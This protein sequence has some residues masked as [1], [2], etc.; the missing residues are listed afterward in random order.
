MEHVFNVIEIKFND[1]F[2]NNSY[3]YVSQITTDNN[4][5]FTIITSGDIFNAMKFNDW[6]VYDEHEKKIRKKLLELVKSYYP[7]KNYVITYHNVK[8]SY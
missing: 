2:L 5:N 3:E 4:G 7:K 8:I 6:V 1:D